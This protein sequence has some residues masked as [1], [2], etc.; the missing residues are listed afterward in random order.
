M[1]LRPLLIAL[2]FAAVLAPADARVRYVTDPDAPRALPEQGP[3]SVRWEDP[4][5]FSDLRYSGNRYEMFVHLENRPFG[6]YGYFYWALIACN[7]LTPQCL[8]FKNIRTNPGIL[9]VV[10]II[11]YFAIRWAFGWYVRKKLV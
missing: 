1:N 7:V 8:W 10:S 9:F 6:P 11:Y 3:V 5:K 4:S 2:A